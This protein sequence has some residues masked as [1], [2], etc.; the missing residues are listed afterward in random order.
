L[1]YKESILS[2]LIT[3]FTKGKF[4][5]GWI[6]CWIHQ[7]QCTSLTSNNTN[8]RQLLIAFP[9]FS[10]NTTSETININSLIAVAFKTTL[11]I[12]KSLL[13]IWHLQCFGR[14]QVDT[15]IYWCIWIGMD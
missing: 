10:V 1:V 15:T 4:D 8:K 11:F 12:L 5:Q 3:N 7:L 6:T 14:N 9:S 13:R 2:G